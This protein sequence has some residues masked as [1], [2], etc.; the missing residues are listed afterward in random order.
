L[1]HTP[2]K[3]RTK[4]EAVC[5]AR[6]YSY[7]IDHDLGFAP[8]IQRRICTLCGCKKTTIEKW[9]QAGSWVVGIG[10]NGTGKPNLLI[11]ALKVQET[12]PYSEFK[13]RHP[14]QSAYLLRKRIRADAPVLVS[15][16][17]YYFGDQAIDVGAKLS[18]IVP[19]TQG[20]KRLE[21]PDIELLKALLSPYTSGKHGKPCN[22][23][24]A[25][26]CKEKPILQR[27]QSVCPP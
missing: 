23:C 9:A 24:A 11:Y 15:H 26:Q 17:F 13:R 8:H 14:A 7:R 27:R 5:E 3:K 21:G 25:P 19:H 2:A 10:G 1:E 12:L 16:H 22:A 6:H 18:H 20:C 4:E